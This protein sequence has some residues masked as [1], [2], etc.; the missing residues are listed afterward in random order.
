MIC[1]ARLCHTKEAKILYKIITGI[2]ITKSRSKEQEN[3]YKCIFKDRN[4]KAEGIIQMKGK[5]V[6]CKYGRSQWAMAEICDINKDYKLEKVKVKWINSVFNDEEICWSRVE[7][8][9][10]K[11]KKR[12][13]N[14]YGF[15]PTIIIE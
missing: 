6:M 7:G 8:V 12:K 5:Q 9:E 10:S 4:T 15:P 1:V 3:I 11:R 14:K 2:D 13:P